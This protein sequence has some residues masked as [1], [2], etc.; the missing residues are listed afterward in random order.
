MRTD[1]CSG[2]TGVYAYI[3]HSA[4]TPRIKEKMEPVIKIA[5]SPC[6]LSGVALT[7]YALSLFG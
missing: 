5:V 7:M 3:C 4:K 6:R 2:V 1:Q